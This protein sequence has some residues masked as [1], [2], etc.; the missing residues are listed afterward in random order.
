MYVLKRIISA[1]LAITMIT[2]INIVVFADD[3][4][5]IG[6][7]LIVNGDFET[8]DAAYDTANTWSF[9]DTGIWYLRE[10]PLWLTQIIAAEVT[11]VHAN[12]GSG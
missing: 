2:G 11:A 10:A 9:S 8:T 3:V 7:E 12:C 1:I 5:Q 4:P 6:A